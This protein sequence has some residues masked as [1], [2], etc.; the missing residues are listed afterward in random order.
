MFELHARLYLLDFTY[1]S[2]CEAKG[3]FFFAAGV[4]LRLRPQLLPSVPGCFLRAA[5]AEEEPLCRDWTKCCEAQ[6][7]NSLLLC[8]LHLLTITHSSAVRRKCL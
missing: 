1:G 8:T 7:F 6:L 5:V 3:R 4:G 2:V